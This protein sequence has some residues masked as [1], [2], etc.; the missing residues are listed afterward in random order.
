[1]KIIAKTLAISLLLILIG[2]TANAQQSFRSHELSG[3]RDISVP[4]NIIEPIE[5]PTYND[6]HFYIENDFRI[7]DW[8]INTSSWYERNNEPEE[9]L[10]DWMLKNFNLRDINLSELVKVQPERP[11]RLQRWMYC[12]DEWKSMDL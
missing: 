8:M 12:C 7:E 2:S 3:T 4:R 9:M 1:M 6:D 10:E 11:L 5:N